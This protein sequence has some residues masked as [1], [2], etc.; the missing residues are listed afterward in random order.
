MSKCKY[1]TIQSNFV[2]F[3]A[4]SLPFI[5]N[6]WHLLNNWSILNEFYLV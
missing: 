1:D 3:G 2:A 6:R 4:E 5:P